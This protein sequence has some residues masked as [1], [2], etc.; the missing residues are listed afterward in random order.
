MRVDLHPCFILHQRP[1]RETS[2]ILDVFSLAHGRVSLVARG[3]KRRRNNSAPLL[4]PARRLN[5]SWSMR[6]DLGTLTG[7]EASGPPGRLA[8]H[9]LVSCFYMNELLVRILHRHESHPE[10]F[11]RYEQALQ[12]LN[13]GDAEERVLRIFEKHLLKSLGYGLILDQET[14]TGGPVLEEERYFYRMGHGPV[15]REPPNEESVRVSGRTLKALQDESAW[16]EE[17]SR[18]AKLLFRMVLG[19]H[20]GERPL[21]SRELYKAYL[22]N[23]PVDEV[24]ATEN[25]EDL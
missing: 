13:A 20:T 24:K 21:G 7:V 22:R 2:L 19:A 14:E 25:T 1:Y 5:I 6:S 11:C 17:T 9:R 10:L 12:R 8:G 18:E 4:Q 3:A 15:R 16:D 23:T